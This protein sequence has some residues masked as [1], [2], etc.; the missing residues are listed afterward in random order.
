[1]RHLPRYGLK[2]EA[3]HR[4]AIIPHAG[5]WLKLKKNVDGYWLQYSKSRTSGQTECDAQARRFNESNQSIEFVMRRTDLPRRIKW[6]WEVG[7]RA[8]LTFQ[9]TQTQHFPSPIFLPNT[10]SWLLSIDSKRKFSA[11]CFTYS[12][13]ICPHCID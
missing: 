10:S 11:I 8:S 9:P 4:L 3:C 6:P 7:W 5:I 2:I 12:M 1:M 13:V